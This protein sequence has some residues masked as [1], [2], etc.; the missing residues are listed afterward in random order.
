MLKRHIR[1]IASASNPPREVFLNDPQ[2]VNCGLLPKPN[3]YSVT[4]DGEIFESD[5]RVNTNFTV[6]MD[7]PRD[8][9]ILVDMMTEQGDHSKLVI[10][11]NQGVCEVKHITGR[12]I[13]CRLTF[14]YMSQLK[15]GS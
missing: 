1:F 2:E 15:K 5:D 14:E 7:P 12:S 6:V 11:P 10:K 9:R 4:V 8:C 3:K 13:S